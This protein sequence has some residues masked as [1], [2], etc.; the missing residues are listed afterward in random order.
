MSNLIGELSVTNLFF[1]SYI[2]SFS[3]DER[4]EI[5]CDFERYRILVINDFRDIS[6]KV[7]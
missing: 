1:Q 7:P 2:Y 6:E 5:V 3:E 4:Q